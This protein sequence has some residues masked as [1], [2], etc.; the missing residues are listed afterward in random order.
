MPNPRPGRH[1]T[2]L[3]FDI[4]KTQSQ[5]ARLGQR[6]ILL[7]QWTLRAGALRGHGEPGYFDRKELLN[8]Q[9]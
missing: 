5:K 9:N 7:E 8:L 2:A 6:D 1:F 3:Y 4:L